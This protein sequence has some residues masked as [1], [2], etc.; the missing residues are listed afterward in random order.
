MNCARCD[1]Q[2]VENQ[3][4]CSTCGAVH[5]PSAPAMQ[6]RLAPTSQTEEGALW[7]FLVA[8]TEDGADAPHWPLTRPLVEVG[9]QDAGAD[10]EIALP[11][12]TVSF[13][14]AVLRYEGHPPRAALMD[15]G[16]RNGSFVNGER[17]TPEQTHTLRDGDRLRFG[18]YDSLIK[19]IE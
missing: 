2:L 19:I 15:R 9:R 13:A 11:H 7:G 12:Q 1:E 17:L 4:S 6:A 8:V 5:D 3:A 16:S 14:H 18:L 10:V